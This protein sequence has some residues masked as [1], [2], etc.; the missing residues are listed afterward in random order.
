ME[1]NVI[2]AESTDAKFYDYI[3]R[4]MNMY[5]NIFHN[6]LVSALLLSCSYVFV[7]SYHKYTCN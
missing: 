1:I 7:V 3:G 4:T 5:K 6:V 2:T